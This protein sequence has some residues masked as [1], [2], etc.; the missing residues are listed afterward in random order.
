[1]FRFEYSCFFGHGREHIRIGTWIPSQGSSHVWDF[2]TVA[3]DRIG[4]QLDARA[5]PA[6]FKVRDYMYLDGKHVPSLLDH[7]RRD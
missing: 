5:R 6:E 2:I 1:M 7:V 3:Q 4:I